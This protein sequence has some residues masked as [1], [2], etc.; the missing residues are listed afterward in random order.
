M[1]TLRKKRKLAAV[2]KHPKIQGTVSRKTHLI[3]EWLKSTSFLKSLKGVTKKLS[4]DFSRTETRILVA[5]S[6]V[7]EFLLNPQVRTCSVAVPGTSRNNGSENREPTGDRS[8]GDSCP[9]AVFSACHS[10]NLNDSEQ[11][12]THNICIFSR[13]LYSQKSG[14]DG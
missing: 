3:R 10:N 11:E 1:V 2:S 6:K 13:P 4:R 14:L 8:L 12:K 7:E 9:E 5:L